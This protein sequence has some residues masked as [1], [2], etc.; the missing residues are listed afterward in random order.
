MN[1][2]IQNQ[3]NRGKPRYFAFESTFT[4]TKNATN[5]QENGETDMKTL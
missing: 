3:N 4:V 2:K 5:Y 1:K